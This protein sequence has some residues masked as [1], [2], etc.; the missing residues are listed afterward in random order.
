MKGNQR[1]NYQH[2]Q[3]ATAL[4]IAAISASLNSTTHDMGIPHPTDGTR[5]GFHTLQNS[6]VA[7]SYEQVAACA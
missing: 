5:P 4:A 3:A 7:L 6:T 1:H 2:N